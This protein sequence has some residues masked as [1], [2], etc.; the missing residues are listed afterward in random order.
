M[1]TTIVSLF[2]VFF[3]L[4]L[5]VET[6]LL[7]LNLRHAERSRGVP[8]PLEG[9]VAPDVA[10]KS[11]AYTVANGRFALL[12]GAYGAA[13]TL[14]VLFSGALPWLD[15]ALRGAGLAGA[16]LFV[17]WL[18]ILSVALGLA[19]VPFSLWHTFVL[20]ARF[21]FNRTTF[22]LWLAD[23]LKGLVVSTLLGVP[24]LYATYLFMRFT[25][26]LWWIWL[27]AFLTAFQLVLLWLWPAVIAPLFNR[28][29]PL[30][31]GPLRTRLEAL[32]A[33]A[34]F[35]NRGLYV[36]D[37]SKRSGHSNAY[38]TGLFRP[39]IVLFDTLVEKMSVDEAASVLAHEIGHYRE[40]H[41]HRRMAVSLAGT[42]VVLFVLSR[43]VGWAPL[44]E[45]FGFDA[46]SLHAAVALFSLAGG[47]FVFWLAPLS[48]RLSRRHEYQADRYAV[49]LAR[50]P[51]AL[52]SAL[53]RL[54]GENLSNLHPH[55]WFSAWHYSH[56]ALVE[57]LA[58]IDRDGACRPTPA[59]RAP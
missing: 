50:A 26:G 25:G 19:N 3:A 11:R 22:R 1:T 30:P 34:G 15:R 47:A 21:G 58:A 6:T 51:E 27:F 28:F 41:I 40:K 42:L 13:L 20:E 48:S 43:L 46:A 38:F 17:A 7:A 45:A 49:R 52:K 57:R 35:R 18:A 33:E 2:L 37:A 44:Y 36:M 12:H 55:P 16:H 56:P 23:R 32:A 4:E 59:R 5:A 24:L 31:E 9:R 29:A 8:A 53:V 14:A 10:E 54:N 39:R